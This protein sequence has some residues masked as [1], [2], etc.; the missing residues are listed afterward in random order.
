M[1]LI[2]TELSDESIDLH[3]KSK[4]CEILV[5][6]SKK[7]TSYYGD[8]YKEDSIKGEI[9]SLESCRELLLW[10]LSKENTND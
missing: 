5:N 10:L 2:V 8:N 9:N 1:K 3:Y 7:R 4:N 6:V